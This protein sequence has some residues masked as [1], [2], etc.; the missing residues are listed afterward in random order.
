MNIVME[1]GVWILILLQH[2]LPSTEETEIQ[3]CTSGLGYIKI[4]ISHKQGCQFL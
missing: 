3:K 1:I 2:E 4:L